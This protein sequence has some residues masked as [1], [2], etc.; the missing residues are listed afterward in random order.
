MATVSI[1]QP[2]SPRNDEHTSAGNPYSTFS[3]CCA[4][5]STKEHAQLVGVLSF[6]LFICLVVVSLFLFGSLSIFYITIGIVIYSFLMRSLFSM[7]EK[8]YV[9]AYLVFEALQIGFYIALILY[10][11]MPLVLGPSMELVCKDQ[12]V[13]SKGNLIPR[14]CRSED[15]RAVL[16]ELLLC[17]VLLASVKL[18]FTRVFTKYYKF[19][20]WSEKSR[21]QRAQYVNGR[22]VRINVS[23]DIFPAPP[24][25]WADPITR[26]F[27]YGYSINN[28]NGVFPNL[29]TYN[30]AMSTQKRDEAD[31]APSNPSNNIS[32]AT[33][34]D[35]LPGGTPP[36][37]VQLKV[38]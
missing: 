17:V 31:Q 21:Q 4:N 24:P 18:Y 9:L 3:C 37:E 15:T 12:F 14:K 32:V 36:T 29:P 34:T 26:E 11:M 7:P 8:I 6:S 19:V 38:Q 10:I 25:L 16:A 33:T 5:F 35:A 13:D 23:H 22:D 20:A 28:V 1:A 30:Q 27:A 2:R